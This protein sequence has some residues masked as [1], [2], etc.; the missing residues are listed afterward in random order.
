MSL[1]VIDQ[2]LQTQFPTIM[3]PIH[4]TL[5]KLSQLGHRFLIAKNG[6]WLEIKRTWLYG[7]V[8]ISPPSTVAIPYGD[9]EPELV[10]P[11]IP[12]ELLQQFQSY[13]ESKLPME[14]AARIILN[15]STMQMRIQFLESVDV[16]RGHINYVLDSLASDE[17]CFFDIHSHGYHSAFFS[18]TDDADDRG[19][20]KIAGVLSF[21]KQQGDSPTQPNA[22]FR[23]CLNGHFLNLAW[24]SSDGSIQF[25]PKEL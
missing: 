15:N 21:K 24:H 9:V 11:K 8:Q 2:M 23:L 10:L 14:C 6:L 4:E 25:M 1:N 5:G 22:I 13:A 3:V 7:R 19:E 17:V 12:R 20:T 18:L 16:S